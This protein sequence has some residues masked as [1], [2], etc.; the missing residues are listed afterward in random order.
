MKKEKSTV[1]YSSRKKMPKGKTDWDRMDAQT[2]EDIERAVKDDPDAAPLVDE[3]WFE[4]AELV[5]PGEGKEPVTIRLDTDVVQWFKA[6]GRGYQ[7]RINAVLRAYVE[8]KK[9]S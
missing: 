2:D 9:A 5:M 7:T 3:K 1:V 4:T 8:T 6:Q